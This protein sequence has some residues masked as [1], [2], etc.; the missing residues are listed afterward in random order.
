MSATQLDATSNIPG[1]FAYS[2]PVGTVLGAG[3]HSLAVIFTPTD[4]TDFTT[5]SADTTIV[6]AQA[7][8]T[9]AW[10]DPAG[11]GYGMALSATQLDATVSVPGTFAYTPAS[12]T[13]LGAGTH[14]LSATFTPTDA[15]DYATA[16]AGVTIVVAQAAPTIIWASPAGI[17]F[18]TARS[19]A[20]L[21]ATASVAGG[22]S[23]SP[24]AGD[25]PGA[26]VQTLSVTFTPVEQQ[27]LL[28]GQGDD[29]DPRGQNDA[30]R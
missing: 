3:T 20:Q 11:I 24:A 26:G 13:V 25:I 5:A 17:V 8:L 27:G 28:V 23:Y 15:T 10:P 16:T 18:G 7:M 6:V 9:I 4:T 29:D 2:P 21:D 30:D 12:G 1:T 14:T 22:F 19:S